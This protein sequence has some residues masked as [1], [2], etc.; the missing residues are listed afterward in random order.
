MLFVWLDTDEAKRT[1]EMKKI[2]GTPLEL[3]KLS[4]ISNTSS[5]FQIF[6]VTETEKSMENGGFDAV[7]DRVALKNLL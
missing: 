6:G 1:E 7:Y 4:T 2:E 3:Q 5:I